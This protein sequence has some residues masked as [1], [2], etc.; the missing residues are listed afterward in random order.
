MPS[1]KKKFLM[2]DWFSGFLSYLNSPVVTLIMIGVMLFHIPMA[3]IHSRRNLS[4]IFMFLTGLS[5]VTIANLAFVLI[6]LTINI[7]SGIILTVIN[8]VF[9]ILSFSFLIFFHFNLKNEFLHLEDKFLKVFNTSP[10]GMIIV[11]VADSAIKEVNTAFERVSGYSPE[12]LKGKTTMGM[13]LW[14]NPGQRAKVISVMR[15]FETYGPEEIKFIPKSGIPGKYYFTAQFILIKGEKYIVAHIEEKVK[16]NRS[17][18]DVKNLL[19]QQLR[20]VILKEELFKIPGLTLSDLSEKLETN[21]TYL[22]QAINSEYGNFSDYLNKLR[23]VE[24]CRLIQDG[25]DPKFSID[26]LY[27]EVGFSARTTFYAAFKKFTGVSPSQFR[28]I[29]RKETKQTQDRL[30]DRSEPGSEVES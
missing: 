28:Q 22:S 18:D 25:L 12:E 27:S 20:E 29:N 2:N 8:L 14:Q 23:I 11:K 3:R 1:C 7:S 9:L 5:L 16:K 15:N 17:G 21:K 24:A 26:Y 19:K 13:G 4:I 10:H 30:T 6:P